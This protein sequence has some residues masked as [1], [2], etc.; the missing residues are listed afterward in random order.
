MKISQESFNKLVALLRN[1]IEGNNITNVMK[2]S[3]PHYNSAYL[4]IF[5]DE[6]E[7]NKYEPIGYDDFGEQLW[8][9]LDQDA[10]KHA[11][12]TEEFIRTWRAWFD[13]YQYLNKENKLKQNQL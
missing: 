10:E 8:L 7:K 2:I 1:V 11:K 4:K 5:L 12:D 6:A 9:I 3:N 13:L